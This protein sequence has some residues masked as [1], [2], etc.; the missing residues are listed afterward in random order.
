M[1]FHMNSQSHCAE[2]MTLLIAIELC[3]VMKN[4]KINP[5]KIEGRK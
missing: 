1:T 5:K 4:R 2:E 3:M